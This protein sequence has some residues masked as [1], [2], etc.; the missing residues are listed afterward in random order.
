MARVCMQGESH[1]STVAALER[2]EAILR[3]EA[4]ESAAR[5]FREVLRMLAEIKGRPSGE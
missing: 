2:C 4:P 1:T 3:L 5:R